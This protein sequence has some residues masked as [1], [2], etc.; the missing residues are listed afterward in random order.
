M[1]SSVTLHD[2]H[3]QRL[4]I[5]LIT[6]RQKIFDD[7]K[8]QSAKS[9][10]RPESLDESQRRFRYEARA[11]AVSN[12]AKSPRL[13]PADSANGIDLA[14]PNIRRLSGVTGILGPH[15][16]RPPSLGLEPPEPISLDGGLPPGGVDDAPSA[17]RP[18]PVEVSITRDS[19]EGVVELP[20]K[21][22]SLGR[23]HRVAGSRPGLQRHLKRDS[24][25][26]GSGT[27]AGDVTDKDAAAV[28]ANVRRSFEGD[29]GGGVTLMDGPAR[30]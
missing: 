7:L 22:P 4:L 24:L 29:R 2:R 30:Q 25:Q 1:E 13:P 6:H 15:A 19:G 18:G 10:V 20:N 3:V 9:K 23:S 8:R 5:D 27:V 16:H 12:A 28:A 17:D 14:P 26:Q 11:R 21:K